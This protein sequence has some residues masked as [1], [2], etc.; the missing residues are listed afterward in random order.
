MTSTLITNIGQ[1]VT[2]DPTHDGTKLGLINDAALLIEDGVIAWAGANSQ[3]PTKHIK[4]H[5]DAEGMCVLPGY[6]DSHT[7]MIFAGDRSNE[8]RARMLGESY[9]AGGIA[10]T[11]EK[12]RKASDELLLA[13]AKFL[14]AEAHS[15]GTTTL[16]IKSGYGLS[17]H[18][19]QRCLEIASQITDETTFLGAHVV[20]VE[21]KDLPKDYV[22]LVCGEMLDAVAPF[23]K[24]IDV[25]CDK[26]AFA[27]EDARRILKAGIAK[28]LLPRIHANQLQEGQGVMLGVELDAASVDHVSHLTEADIEAL[29]TSKT[30]ATLLPGAEFSTKSA[31]PDV[32]PLLEASIAVALASDCN[33][34]SSYTTSMAFIIAMAVREM[35]FSPEQAVWSATMGGAKALRRDD[36]GHLV[37]GARADFQI[38]NAPSHIHL[39]YRPGV[40]LV[41]QVWRNGLQ[42]I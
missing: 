40:N 19:E 24:W 38:L 12:T 15:G 13:H 26:G 2:N 35:H 1:L 25:F 10:S 7:H 21:Y 11:V 14:A 18:D 6:V 27:V 8:F 22:D 36:I 30:V 42:L 17:V 31:Y 39:A 32:R 23:A 33:P 28:G 4:T 20:P 3:A 16:E 5:I 29:S 37:E 41:E 9:T 34:G